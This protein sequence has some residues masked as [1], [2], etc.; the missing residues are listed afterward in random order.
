M[1][2]QG[3]TGP[4]YVKARDPMTPQE[5]G[6]LGARRKWGERRIVRLDALDPAVR[7]VVVN[8]VETAERIAREKAAAVSETSA[9]A[10]AEVRG[11]SLDSAA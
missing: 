1:S 5:A 10:G 11:A 4:L 2:G 7:A 9:T 8:L 6:R 3:K